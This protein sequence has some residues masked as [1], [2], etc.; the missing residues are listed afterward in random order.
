[1]PLGRRAKRAG[2]AVRRRLQESIRAAEE[3]ELEANVLRRG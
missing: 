1:M 2:E 3:R